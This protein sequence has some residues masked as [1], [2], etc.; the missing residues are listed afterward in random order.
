MTEPVTLDEVATWL[1]G[2]VAIDEELFAVIGGWSTDEPS[3]AE[4]IVFATTS[5]WFGGHAIEARSLLPDSPALAALERIEVPVDWAERLSDLPSAP[6]RIAALASILA[7]RRA[8]DHE[9]GG[10]LTPVADAP[11]RRHLAR[12]ALDLEAAAV[13][14]SGP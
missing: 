5:R 2:S 3:A 1:A 7:D 9:F 8:R 12:T 11:L 4:R 6:D 14:L 10:R 13:A